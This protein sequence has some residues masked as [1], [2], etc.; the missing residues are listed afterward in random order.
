MA[1]RPNNHQRSSSSRSPREGRCTICFGNN[2]VAEKKNTTQ[3]GSTS[4]TTANNV[5]SATN[6][7]GTTANAVNTANTN[8]TAN[9]SYNESGI[10]DWLTGASQGNIN[11]LS[12]L[13]DAGYQQY[14]GPRVADLNSDQTG[15]ASIIRAL[16]GSNNPYAS[17]IQA[18]FSN[19]ANAPASQVSTSRLIDNVPGQGAS[20]STQDYMDPYLEAVLKPQLRSIDENSIRNQNALDARATMGG[21]FGDTRSGFEA[22]QNTRDTNNLRNDTVGKAYSQAFTDAMARKGIDLNRILDVGKTNAGLNETAL[23]RGF[24][25]GAALEGL[26]KYN[27]GRTADLATMLGQTGTAERGVDQA[28]MDAAYEEFSKKTGFPLEVSKLLMSAINGTPYSKT[29]TG[30]TTGTSLGSGS[31]IGS[32]QTSNATT[33]NTAS[34]GSTTGLSNLSGLTT[35]EKPDNSGWGILASLLG[36]VGKAAMA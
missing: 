7:V 10:P 9:T 3:A 16:A 20:G 8:N 17:Q 34:E 32:G 15:A 22:A 4:G 29:S 14:Q 36:T 19:G 35:T 12:G 11:F 18:L 2:T 26:D 25:G 24:T 13:R 27:T 5:Q 28:K 6:N 33:G 31:T 30:A 23:N 21:A 1:T